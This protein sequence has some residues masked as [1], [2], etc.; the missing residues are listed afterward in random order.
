MSLLKAAKGIL[1]AIAPTI[2]TAL[3]G[4][5]GGVAAKALTGAL[6]ISN[7]STDEEISNALL[8][9]DPT[10]LAEIKKI[11]ANF[12][13][14]SNVAGGNFKMGTFTIDAYPDGGR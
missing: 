5:M 14:E 13:V 11:E 12:K 4:P 8:S 9:A 7:K 3:G 10:K 2:G 1:G 6:G